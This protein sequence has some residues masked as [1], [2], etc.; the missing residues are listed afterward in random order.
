MPKTKPIQGDQL[1][2]DE[3]LPDAPKSNHKPIKKAIRKQ[4]LYQIKKTP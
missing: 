3:L 1:A 4:A 2:L